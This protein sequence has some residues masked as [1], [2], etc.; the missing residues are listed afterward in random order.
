LNISL[1]KQRGE[2]TELSANLFE[3]IEGELKKH[4]LKF[5]IKGRTKSIF[6]IWRKMSKNNIEF[7][8][9]YDI[10]AIRIILD[11]SLS[12][13][14]EDCWRTYSIVTDIYKPNPLR[15]RD[16]ISIPK[17]NGYESLHSTVIGP[18]GNWV[19]VQI[20]S[21]RMDEIAEKG[22]AAHWKYKTDSGEGGLDAWINNVRDLLDSPSRE[23]DE[24]VEEFKQGLYGKE[25]IHIYSKG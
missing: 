23:S 2:E 20:R 7:E 10:F 21:R 9:V 19:E 12:N 6:S 16:W 4:K 24:L 18:S 22:L 13:E 8:E 5:E 3:P 17:S 14:K 11:S 1:R 15:M 25:I